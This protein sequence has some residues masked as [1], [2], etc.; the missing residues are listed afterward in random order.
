MASAAKKLSINTTKVGW[1]LCMSY[2]FS[3]LEIIV[4]N[5]RDEKKLFDQR[6]GTHTLNTYEKSR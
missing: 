1:V 5:P 2:E 3:T 6:P 4:T